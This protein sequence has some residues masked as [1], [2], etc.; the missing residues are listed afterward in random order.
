MLTPLG[1]HILTPNG[2]P[3][4]CGPALSPGAGRAPRAAQLTSASE[5]QPGDLSDSERCYFITLA[6]KL[7][8]KAAREPSPRLLVSFASEGLTYFRHS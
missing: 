6:L 3:G 1:L 4:G 8:P 5:L 2:G 7:W